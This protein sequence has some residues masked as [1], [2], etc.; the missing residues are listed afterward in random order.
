M[1]AVITAIADAATTELNSGSFSQ[2]LTAQRLHLPRFELPEMAELRVSVVP[3]GV[4]IG[5]VARHQTAERYRIDVGV[6]KKLP[7][8]A[9]AESDEA[10]AL[11]KLAQEIGQFFRF[12]RLAGFP[13]VVWVKTEHEPLYDPQHFEQLRQFTAVVRLTFQLMG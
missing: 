5:I 7:A 8:D 10:D 9:T 1:S 11:L 4:E 3:V 2:P 6:Q 13:Q 12:R